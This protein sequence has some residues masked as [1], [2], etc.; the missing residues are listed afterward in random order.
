M[1]V[2]GAQA[3]PACS[4]ESVPLQKYGRTMKKFDVLIGGATYPF[5]FDSGGGETI[6]TP[7]LAARACGKVYGRGAGFRANGDK[8]T[9]G[10]CDGLPMKLGS[11]ELFPPS[12]AVLDIMSYFPPQAPKI[13]GA[14]SLQTFRGKIITLDVPGEKLTIETARSAKKKK[15]HMT[16]L[17]S[18]F[19]TGMSGSE[20][21][22][23]VCQRRNGVPY[24]F[25]FDTGNGYHPMISPQTA[26]EW[27]L[28]KDPA[29]TGTVHSVEITLGTLKE[30]FN[31]DTE[32]LIYDGVLNYTV[33]SKRSYLI[34]FIRNEIWAD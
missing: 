15:K 28:Q 8:V 34:D 9:Y 4:Q 5:L 23:L 33:V 1:L 14:L 20:L 25:L 32:D 12:V 21:D 7:D 27:G 30:N 22:I 19:P 3:L 18:R 11:T 2:L 6:I 16:L 17:E 13:Y 31:F 26:F 24:W 10:R 29:S